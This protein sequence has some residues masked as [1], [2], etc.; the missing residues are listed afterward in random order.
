M[1]GMKFAD[2]KTKRGLMK[3]AYKHIAPNKK[4]GKRK[5]GKK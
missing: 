3:S 1:T 5:G 4:R 2:P